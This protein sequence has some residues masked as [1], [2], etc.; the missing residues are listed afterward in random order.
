MGGKDTKDGWQLALLTPSASAIVK[1][2]MHRGSAT[3]EDSQ[4]AFIDAPTGA[5]LRHAWEIGRR[6]PSAGRC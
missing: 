1:I 3:R 2:D 5:L 4:I 6:K